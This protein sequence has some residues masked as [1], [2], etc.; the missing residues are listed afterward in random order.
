MRQVRICAAERGLDA[1]AAD[2][3]ALPYRSGCFDAAI[4][5]A[6]LHHVSSPPRRARLVAECLRVVRVGGRA[7]FY[8]WAMVSAG[9]QPPGKDAKG[10]TA[11]GRPNEAAQS[12]AEGCTSRVFESFSLSRPP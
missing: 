10:R 9:A 7:L 4:S 5:I 1:L 11:T 12:C 8:A 6:V 2:S 3:L